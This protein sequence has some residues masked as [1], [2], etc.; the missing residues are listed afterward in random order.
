[1]RKDVALMSAM[2]LRSVVVTKNCTDTL[3]SFYCSCNPGY[4]LLSDKRTCVDID[5][6]KETPFICSQKCENLPGTYICKCAPGYIREPD[7]KT[8]RQNSNI[9]L[10]SF[11]ATVTI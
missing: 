9:G 4:K 10:I 7:G 6:C 1:M 2:T 8:C 11:L 5:E 3:T